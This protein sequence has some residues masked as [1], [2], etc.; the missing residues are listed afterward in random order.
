M[1]KT[2]GELR[3]IEA[4]MKVYQEVKRGSFASESLRVISE[5]VPEKERTLAASLV[6]SLFRRE[7]LW[8]EI[9]GR[10]LKKGRDGVSSA[11][12][13]ALMVGTAGVLDLR[14]F[15]A[16]VL[17]N[18]LV[19]WTKIRDEKGAKVVN[20]VLRRI[21]EDGP[22]VMREIEKS[23]VF[24]D[25]AMR[26]GVP[27]W[28]AWMFENSLGKDEA[29]SLIE[30]QSLPSYL[31]LRVYPE[32][33]RE[34]AM[35]NLEKAGYKASFSTVFPFSLRIEGTALPTA[36]PGHKDGLITPQS[37]SSMA[38]LLSLP[39]SAEGPFLEM[40]CG[41]GVKTGQL[42]QMFPGVSIESWDMS[43][44]KVRA[45]KKEMIRLGLDG[46]VLFKTGD[47]LD[48][49]QDF[50]PRT[51]IVD[52][53]CSGSGTWRR[54]PESK[55]RLTQENLKDYASLQIKLLKRALELAEPGGTVLYGTCSLFKE[56]NEKVVARAMADCPGL[57]ELE[58][59]EKIT[60]MAKKGR[61]YGYYIW[62]D[63]PWTDGF[64]MALLAVRH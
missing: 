28:C 19:E 17:V 30:L 2:L 48:L 27:L 46:K 59:P 39:D 14:T 47:A 26:N 50:R 15:E 55:W 33:K 54:H 31:S 45:A 64:Y 11:A 52:A 60:S 62:P 8:R 22:G 1:E 38:F 49:V 43:A 5:K 25:L 20:A 51:V 9:L 34:L 32:D 56:E 36:L 16:R 21:S 61:P 7:S 3:G 12:K 35:N 23:A 13:S 57:A 4:A 53:P 10:F 42:A 63:T 37:E 24:P 58:P 44:P 18:G 6:Y 29:R 41:R 40:C